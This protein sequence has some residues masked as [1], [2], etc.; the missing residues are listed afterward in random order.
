MRLR[1]STLAMVLAPLGAQA[2]TL[3]F[4]YAGGHVS[5]ASG[6]SSFTTFSDP[7][8][9]N[10]ASADATGL[11]VLLKQAVVGSVV[12][13]GADVP[14]VMAFDQLQAS[15][16]DRGGGGI[17]DSRL[18]TS[19]D[20]SN[21]FWVVYQQT[22]V[23]GASPTFGFL[24]QENATDLVPHFMKTTIDPFYRNGTDTYGSFNYRYSAGLWTFLPG[25]NPF[26]LQKNWTAFLVD[27]TTVGGVRNFQIHDG[28]NFNNFIQSPVPEPASLAILAVGVIALLRRRKPR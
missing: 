7:I 16:V 5:F 4:P 3:T 17:W 6:S 28:V 24:F 23:D 25:S 8:H 15:T 19:A 20:L 21:T 9:M 26:T 12:T 2:F 14:G 13:F 1:I 18:T 27:D 22:S 10:S 11:S